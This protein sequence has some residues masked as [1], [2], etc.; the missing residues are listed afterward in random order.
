[1]KAV[2]LYR[3]EKC[4]QKKKYREE[5]EGEMTC[6]WSHGGSGFFYGS[7]EIF[8]SFKKKMW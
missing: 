1:M 7:P 4:D 3:E 5:K 6:S 8:D 2:L